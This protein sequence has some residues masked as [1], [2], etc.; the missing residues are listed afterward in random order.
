MRM[1]HRSFYILAAL[2]I[3]SQ[4]RANV[5]DGVWTGSYFCQQGL[6]ALELFVTI[7]PNGVPLALFHFGDGSIDRPEGCFA[8]QG[9]LS[10]ERMNFTA[11]KWLLRPY[12]Y[13][14]VDLSGIV[15]GNAYAGQVAGPDCTTFTLQ[16][17]PGSPAPA[18]CQ[19]RET[20]IS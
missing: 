9:T 19:A 16:W 3:A 4:V 18:A 6:T 17:R 1:M 7:S 20:P 10:K 5:L 15:N 8:M 11:G 2:L 12:G 13:V 14:S